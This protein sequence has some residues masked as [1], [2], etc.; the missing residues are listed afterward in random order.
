MIDPDDL[1]GNCYPCLYE[2]EGTCRFRPPVLVRE[3][4]YET[5]YDDLAK[6]QYTPQD[7]VHMTVFPNAHQRCAEFVNQDLLAETKL[8]PMADDDAFTKGYKAGLKA[9]SE[10]DPFK[11]TLDSPTR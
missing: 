3:R 11:S 2:V 7:E 6:A 4:I 9:A 10:E 5:T 8:K 1:K